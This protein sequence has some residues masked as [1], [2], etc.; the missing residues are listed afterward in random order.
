MKMNIS[1]AVKFIV[2]MFFWVDCSCFATVLGAGTLL[3]V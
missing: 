1:R 3:A 2:K